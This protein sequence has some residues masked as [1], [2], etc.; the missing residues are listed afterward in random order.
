VDVFARGLTDMLHTQHLS[1]T[2]SPSGWT[3]L[4][5]V[6]SSGPSATAPQTNVVAVFVRG[7]DGRYFYR[8]RTGTAWSGWLTVDPAQAFR[9]LGAWV[10]T[11][12]YQAL[13][14]ATAVADMSA[15]GVRTLYLSTAR[16]N[17]AT[18]ILFPAQVA[19]WLAAAHGAGIRV[20]GWYVPDY[21]DLT[22]DV[23]RA[24]A[25]SSYVSPA[26]HRFDALG[27][28]IEY[29]LSPPD[30]NAWNAAVATHLARVRAGTT[31][32][33][34]AIPLPPVLMRGW[35]DPDRWATFPWAT[36][37]RLADGMLPQ[38]YWTSFTPANRCP[39]DPQYCAYRYTRD[40]VLLSRQLT[41]L[42]VHAIGGVGDMTTL[43]QL[44]DY[45]RAARETGSIGVSLYDYRTTTAAMWPILQ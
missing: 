5:G 24:L 10:D 19:D 4:G 28:D 30:A 23:R 32:P 14:P 1:A 39:T 25:V 20:V 34:A 13:V 6:L 37:G 11:L 43:M 35:S 17:S 42:P 16:Y 33:I 3:S 41:G 7:S 38:S 26:G 9:G 36:I 21:A 44:S 31:L 12:D 22:R 15:H 27:L 8:Q 29:P 40:N 2:G 18:D 45:V